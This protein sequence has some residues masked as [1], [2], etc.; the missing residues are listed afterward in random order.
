MSAKALEGGRYAY[1]DAERMAPKRG[2]RSGVFTSVDVTTRR[3][4]GARLATLRTEHGMDQGSL[5]V[6]MGLSASALSRLET[7]A[8]LP[9]RDFEWHRK[10][11]GALGLTFDRVLDELY[12]GTT[13][14]PRSGLP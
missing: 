7:G 13:A 2:G 1:Y 4:V 14:D 6:M 12:K 9:P 11:A 5:A 3:L 10:L 8:R